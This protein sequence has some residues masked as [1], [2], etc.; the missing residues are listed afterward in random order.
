MNLCLENSRRRENK[1]CLLILLAGAVLKLIYAV[2]VPYDISPHDLGAVSDWVTYGGGHL[3][4]IQYLYHFRCL[5]QQDPVTMGQFYHPPLFHSVG[6]LLF[7]LFYTEGGPVAPIFELLQ[8]VNTLFA[9]G[10]AFV[11]YRIL[12]HLEVGGKKL[13]TL[14]AFLSFG[15]TLYWLGTALNNDCL[16]TLLQ[17]M[18][19]EQAILWAKKPRMRVII[20]MAL[21][22]GLAMLTK[23]S[24][25]LIAPAIACVFLYEFVRRIRQKDNIAAL[26]GQFAVFA[27][28]S[29]PLG[30]SYVLR[31]WILYQT[32]FNYVLNL[33]TSHFLYIGDCSLL[34]R[35]GL[36]SIQQICSVRLHMNLPKEYCNVW[37]QTFQTMAVDEGVLALN[38]WFTKI[39][40]WLLI[41][42]GAGIVILLL[43]GSIRAVASRQSAALSVKL[44][45]SVGYCV[46]MGSY[47]VF[48]FQYP[49]VCTMN[50]RYIYSTLIFLCAGCGISRKE[51]SPAFQLSIWGYC[52]LSSVLYL[53]CAV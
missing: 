22:L 18:T 36:P 49:H 21:F 50:F 17:V 27:L 2:Q 32:P 19:I 23:T 33:G 53:F 28:I 7:Q 11:G 39:L 40:G 46:L 47:V 12:T 31:N 37:G 13:V 41:W 51:I 16:M 14:T 26:I 24:A 6:A 43:V 4:Y 8:M 38:N 9:C 42:S 15:P 34:Q 3:S 5:V 52:L 48:A 25:V 10:I 20:K 30:T 44:L 45:L 35:L 1:L 29:I